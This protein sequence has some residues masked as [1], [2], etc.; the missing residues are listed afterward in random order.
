[1]TRHAIGAALYAP[2]RVLI[3]EKNRTCIEYDL[4]RPCSASSDE[5]V[6]RVA[7]SLDRKLA[8]LVR[9]RPLNCSYQ[10][11]PRRPDLVYDSVW[12]G[13]SPVR[14]TQEKGEKSCRTG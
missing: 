3:Y 10:L 4:P 7:V 9:K 2:L 5:R 11:S 6:D 12:P 13:V 8:D 1:M 14:A